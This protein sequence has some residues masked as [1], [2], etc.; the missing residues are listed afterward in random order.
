[1]A[2]VDHILAVDDQVDAVDRGAEMTQV[3]MVV[4]GDLE[5]ADEAVA[6]AWP[7]AWRKL[8]SLHDPDRRDQ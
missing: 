5:L 4:C 3:C 1:M 7:I 2:Y 8:N 6:A